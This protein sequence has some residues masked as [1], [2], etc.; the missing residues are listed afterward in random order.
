MRG[1][2]GAVATWRRFR[3]MT[4]TPAPPAAR[5]RAL[6]RQVGH[7]QGRPAPPDRPRSL[8]RRREGGGHAAR[9]V[10]A[11]RP[12]ARRHHP[13]RHQRGQG[14]AGRGGGVHVGGLQRDQR[15]RLPLDDERGAG[16]CRRRSRSPTCAT[17][18]T[19][20]PWSSPRRATSPRTRASSSRSTTTRRPRSSTT[21]R[22]PPTPRTSCTR[23]G[24]SSRTPWCRCRSRRSPPTST[25]CSPS[26]AHVVECD[27]EQNRYVAMPMET[28]GI[29]ASFHKGREELE[30]VCATQSVHETKNFFARYV[31][32]PEGHV[33]VTARDVGG[34]FGQ[35]MFVYREECAVVLA[36]YP[37]RATGQV[38]RGPTREPAVGRSLA[39]RVRAREG[40]RR[41][42][43]HHPGHHRRPRV[44]RRRLRGVPAGMDPMLLPGSVQDPA[45]RVLDRDGV[46]QHHGQGRLP[47]A[48]DVR[49]HRARD[50]ASTTS[51]PRSAS[52]PRSCAVATCSPSATC[53]SPR[54]AATCSRRSRR[55]RRWSRRSS[56][57]TTRRSARSRPRR[58]REGRHLGVGICSYVEPT[59]M[60]EQH[61]RHRGGHGEGRD[62]RPRRRVPRHHLARPE[63][64]DH[65]GADRRRAP[66]RRRTTTSPSCRPTRARRPTDPAPAGAAPRSSPAARRARRPSPCARRC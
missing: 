9:G 48:V 43:R 21:R 23:A 3:A 25:R 28:R 4:T 5:R 55:S 16:W 17:S 58:A 27:V 34:G 19:R 50:G 42:R 47:R 18:A 62:Q 54:R 7:P 24:G 6:H 66:R 38:D 22:P 49:D 8:R 2:G 56:S 64:R 61:A 13:H 41:R 51:P 32:I 44:R 63:H 1:S 59:S 46:D 45:A 52:T 65:D 14:A 37:P 40:G 33:H 11:Q 20:W 35:K 10:P 29:V 31:Q 39:Q 53:R 60:G 36:S 15:S 57:S 26:A 12:R 30:I